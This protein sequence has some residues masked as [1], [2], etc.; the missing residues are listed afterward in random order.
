[1]HISALR[2]RLILSFVGS[3]VHNQVDLRVKKRTYKSIMSINLCYLLSG[4]PNRIS[5][6]ST[7]NPSKIV[8]IHVGDVG[9]LM[10][11]KQ[12]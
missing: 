6:D 8:S 12:K 2:I 4:L 1:M 9:N 11:N 3:Y 7:Y 10:N 5:N